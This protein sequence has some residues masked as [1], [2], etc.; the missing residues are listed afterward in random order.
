MSEVGSLEAEAFFTWGSGS[1]E[2]RILCMK[3]PFSYDWSIGITKL[4]LAAR[5]SMIGG[6]RNVRDAQSFWWRNIELM[7]DVVK[8]LN[9]V[10]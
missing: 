5:G 3:I 10:F 9:E 6:L 2:S 4:T 8:K 1:Q 7:L